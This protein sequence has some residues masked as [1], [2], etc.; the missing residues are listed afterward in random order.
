MGHLGLSTPKVWRD[1]KDPAD[2][3]DPE[4]PED[5]KDP[6]D[7]TMRYSIKPS[8]VSNNLYRSAGCPRRADPLNKNSNVTPR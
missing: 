2:Q 4:E 8:E 3:A 7:H 5:L 1:L 6:V